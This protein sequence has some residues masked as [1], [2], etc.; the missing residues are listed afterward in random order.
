VCGIAQP[1]SDGPLGG[2]IQ[3]KLKF[4]MFNMGQGVQ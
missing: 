3:K 1:L 4:V 2:A